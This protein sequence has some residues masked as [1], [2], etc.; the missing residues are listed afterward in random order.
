[1]SYNLALVSTCSPLYSS[2]LPDFKIRDSIYKLLVQD[3]DVVIHVPIPCAGDTKWMERVYK[4]ETNPLY[5]TLRPLNIKFYPTIKDDIKYDGIMLEGLAFF[6]EVEAFGNVYTPDEQEEGLYRILDDLVSRNK[7]IVLLDNDYVCTNPFNGDHHV[8][9]RVYQKYKHYNKLS[10]IAPMTEYL[11]PNVNFKHLPFPLDVD[12]VRKDIVPVEDR[13]Y[14]CRY[15]GNNYGKTNTHIPVFNKL[16]DFGKVYVNGYRWS[17][18]DKALAPNVKWRS[19]ISMSHDN[20]YNAFSNSVL[21][22]SGYSEYQR[23]IYKDLYHLR[24]KEFLIAGIYI[25]TENCKELIDMMPD[26]TLVFDQIAT[27]DPKELQER[28]SYI[29]SNYINLVN[30]QRECAIEWCRSDKIIK[31]YLEVLEI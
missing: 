20:I 19:A 7:P 30:E 21:G 23:D 27:M 17:Q 28:L 16:S 8:L 4:G 5:H 1:M 11:E 15:I 29:K 24:W 22:I 12:S 31:D 18:E 9:E 25:V 10:V 6:Q 26:G 2:K 13:E 3:H 14:L